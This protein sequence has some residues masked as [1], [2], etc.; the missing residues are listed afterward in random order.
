VA[1]F[2]DGEVCRDARPGAFASDMD[3]VGMHW[4]AETKA[5]REFIEG[6]G[7]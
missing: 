1:A 6:D 5:K 2:N 3:P 4:G 7:G